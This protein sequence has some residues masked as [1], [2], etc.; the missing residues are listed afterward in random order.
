MYTNEKTVGMKK[1]N[2]GLKQ[3]ILFTTLTVLALMAAI[4][5]GLAYKTITDSMHEQTRDYM[6][7][8]CKLFLSILDNHY[9][10]EYGIGQDTS[11]A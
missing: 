5:I 8:Q 6:E 11:G 4:V 2:Q 10:G 7:K 3:K 9:P 1:K